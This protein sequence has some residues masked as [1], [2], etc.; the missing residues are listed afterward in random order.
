MVKG[1]QQGEVGSCLPEAMTEATGVGSDWV[2]VRMGLGAKSGHHGVPTLRETAEALGTEGLHLADDF[3]EGRGWDADGGVH[4]KPSMKP[5]EV[6][7]F[8]VVHD[9]ADEVHSYGGVFGVLGVQAR[10]RGRMATDTGWPTPWKRSTK[11]D[12]P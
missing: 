6:C 11:I 10:E 9:A 4:V 1:K 8:H 12:H 3:K 7:L 5:L 2:G